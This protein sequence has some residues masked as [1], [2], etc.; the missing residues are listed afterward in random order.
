MFTS[1]RESALA[2]QLLDGLSGIE[3]GG[4]AFNPFNIPGCRNVDYTADLDTVFKEEERRL[5]GT[6][7]PVDVIAPGDRLPFV[8]ASLDYVAHSHVLEHFFDPIAA[9]EE[10]MRVLRPG[11]IVYAIV[12][13]AS[14]NSDQDRPRTTLAELLDRH[15]GR[16][17]RPAGLAEAWHYS[18]WATEDVVDLVQYLGLELI[19]VQDVDD[20]AG[21]G[22]TVAFRKPSA[23]AQSF[24]KAL[25]IGGDAPAPHW[26]DNVA[27]DAN[28]PIALTA[29]WVVPIDVHATSVIRLYGWASD[30]VS[31]GPAASVALCRGDDIVG[32]AFYGL[33][34]PDVAAF[35]GRSDLGRL[36]FS[37]ALRAQDLG[38][39]RHELSLRVSTTGGYL[40]VATSIAM[41]VR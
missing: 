22:F 28:L 12:P 15:A 40:T 3:I 13:H 19:A 21:N 14:R 31:E 35:L 8:D 16:V 41:L 36:G 27:I 4:S 39:G 7:L 9:I 25:P 38:L 32:R 23:M 1:H 10:W 18:V 29:M 20:K 6:V 33:E 34:R 37:V 2:H 11:G 30:P 5:A 17:E 24:A 26:M